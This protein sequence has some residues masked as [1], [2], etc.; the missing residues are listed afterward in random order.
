VSGG[1]GVN[2]NPLGVFFNS[3]PDANFGVTS[4]IT[5]TQYAPNGTVTSVLQLPAAT[6][7]NSANGIVTSFSSKSEGSLTLSPD[8]QTVSIMGYS[9]PVGALDVSNSQTPG[10][11]ESGNTDIA[12]PTYRSVAT[13]NTAGQITFT[14]TNSFSGNNGRA[15]VLLPGNQ[16][17]L[18]IGNAG[19][20][21]GGN[22]ITNGTGVQFIPI[23]TT[24]NSLGGVPAVPNTT[25]GQYGPGRSEAKPHR[26]RFIR[27]R[28]RAD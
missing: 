12:S 24:V 2:G 9:A 27:M 4:P 25:G 19:N 18:M 21:N 20:G 10:A 16:N 22:A 7:I 23:G 3:T 15:A 1:A 6:A 13:I 5:L 28:Q 26:S 11:L 17:L 14:Q 8:H